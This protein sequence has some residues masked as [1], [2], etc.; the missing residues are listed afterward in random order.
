MPR[1]NGSRNTTSRTGTRNLPKEERVQEDLVMLATQKD[2]W[3][4]PLFSHVTLQMVLRAKETE[5]PRPRSAGGTPEIPPYSEKELEKHSDFFH[6]PRP[7]LHTKT[8]T[9]PPLR[10]SS[11]QGGEEKQRRRRRTRHALGENYQTHGLTEL[12]V[13]EGVD[14]S[15]SAARM[16]FFIRTKRIPVSL[17]SL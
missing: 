12:Y 15:S 17:V 6:R 13:F 11:G 16:K 9:S 1:G 2:I 7:E 10:Y 8:L 14:P 4:K 5:T 3:R